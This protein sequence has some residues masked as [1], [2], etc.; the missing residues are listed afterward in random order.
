MALLVALSLTPACAH[1]GAAGGTAVGAGQLAQANSTK[2]ELYFGRR[3]S[4]RLITNEEF[5]AF[6]EKVIRPH[7]PGGYTLMQATGFWSS[8]SGEQVEEETVILM[9]AVPRETPAETLDASIEPIR[10]EYCAQFAQQS[11]LRLDTAVNLSFTLAPQA[12]VPAA[13]PAK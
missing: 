8:P 2:V 10:A 11:V 9:V 3:A 4:G 1:R 12:A 7:L 5:K 13:V 6:E